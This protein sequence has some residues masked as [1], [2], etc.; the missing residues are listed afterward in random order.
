MTLKLHFL[1]WSQLGFKNN[2]IVVKLEYIIYLSF[3]YVNERECP[4][5]FVYDGVRMVVVFL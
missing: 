3:D 5:T 2:F 1:N 4:I